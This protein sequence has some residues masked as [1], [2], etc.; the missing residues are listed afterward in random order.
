MKTREG[1]GLFDRRLLFTA[2]GHDSRMFSLR[3]LRNVVFRLGMIVFRKTVCSSSTKGTRLD[4]ED[5]SSNP[6]PRSALSFA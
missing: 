3:S 1:D 6:M 2:V 4:V 5:E